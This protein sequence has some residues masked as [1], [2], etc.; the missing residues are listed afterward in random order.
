VPRLAPRPP[1]LTPLPKPAKIAYLHVRLAPGQLNVWPVSLTIIWAAK[2]VWPHARPNISRTQPPW[3][4]TL[5]IQ[6]SAKHAFSMLTTVSLAPLD[7]FMTL[8]LQAV[9][10]SVLQV[11]ILKLWPVHART[12]NFRVS[13]VPTLHTAPNANP[14]T[15]CTSIAVTAPVPSDSFQHRP[16]LANSV[17]P[18]VRSA[19]PK[20]TVP[21]AHQLTTSRMVTASWYV[22]RVFTRAS[23]IWQIMT[24][25]SHVHQIARSVKISTHATFAPMA[26]TFS[27]GFA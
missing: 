16:T 14:P 22:L 6:P 19:T 11:T 23:K 26:F 2:T 13:P 10:Q 17:P 15:S 5:A 21:S 1:T 18:T 20:P 3:L 9:C 4:A 27:T 12:A 24:T 8:S 7:I 25:A